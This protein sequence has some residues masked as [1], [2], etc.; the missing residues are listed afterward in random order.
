MNLLLGAMM[1]SVS[2]SII[3]G[4]FMRIICEAFTTDVRFSGVAIGY[5]L[6][7]ALVGGC[8]PVASEVMIKGVGVI[9]G[10]IIVSVVCGVI[11]ILAMY[12]LRSEQVVA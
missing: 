5:N 12:M 1:V 10:P 3:T 6:A 9:Y 8:A 7:F 11:G 2:P 4:I